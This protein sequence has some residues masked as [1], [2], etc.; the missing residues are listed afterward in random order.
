MH[1]LILFYEALL[2][3]SKHSSLTEQTQKQTSSFNKRMPS[4]INQGILS[5][6]GTPG[7]DQSSGFA[8]ATM[9]MRGTFGKSSN[10]E[11]FSKS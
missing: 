10:V 6:K 8:N 3:Q 1:E 2:D 11:A 4:E 7:Y 9:V 5:T